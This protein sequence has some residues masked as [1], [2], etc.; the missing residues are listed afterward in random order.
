M[1]PIMTSFGIALGCV[2]CLTAA[3]AQTP[4]HLAFTYA[5]L[6]VPTASCS[7]VSIETLGGGHL[8][9]TLVA[10]KT[11]VN[12][13]NSSG[14]LV[15]ADAGCKTSTKTVI[16]PKGADSATFYVEAAT[17][18][19]YQLSIQA[20]G[21]G[22]V[23][24]QE[25]FF[26]APPP[27][28]RGP[29]NVAPPTSAP[30]QAAAAGYNRL[31]FYDEFNGTALNTSQWFTEDFFSSDYD[32]PAAPTGYT[33]AQ[34]CLTILTDASGFSDGLQTADP[35]F[36][37]GTFQNGG[38]FEARMRFNPLGN[39]PGTAWPAFWTYAM[40]GLVSPANGTQFA[41]LDFLECYPNDP[42]SCI[43]ITTLH[44][45]SVAS[46]GNTSVQNPSTPGN[47]PT[48][49][50]GFDLTAWHVWGCLWTATAVTWYIDNVAYIT[51]PI[52]AGT[53]FTAL[54]NDHMV[55]ILGTGKSWPV[56]FDYVHVWQQ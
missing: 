52:G 26:P 13:G 11:T 21:Y 46:S 22:G 28:C 55:L 34:G 31:A 10:V 41:E 44:Q 50:A 36:T 9:P 20:S 32:L 49:P 56:Q 43:P 25:K 42:H 29:T 4:T 6:D 54:A 16:I 7:A 14:I 33:V 15:Y 45:W 48:L 37:T 18:G 38:Y 35:D 40:E 39:T 1:K 3:K 30:A 5:A 17:A 51:L 12:I 23:T 24:Q 53:N 2:T 8:T 47:I 27:P 19:T